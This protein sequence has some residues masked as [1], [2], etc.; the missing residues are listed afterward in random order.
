MHG[1]SAKFYERLGAQLLPDAGPH[2]CSF[3][4]YRLDSTFRRVSPTCQTRSWVFWT[5]LKR[6]VQLPRG[7]PLEQLP[8]EDEQTQ[9]VQ[10]GDNAAATAAASTAA[11]SGAGAGA[12]VVESVD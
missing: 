11:G 2:A 10:A 8:A 4:G 12:A 7:E 6:P 1:E 9:Q 5:P 3:A